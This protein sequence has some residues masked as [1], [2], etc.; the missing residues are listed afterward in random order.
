MSRWRPFYEPFSQTIRDT[1]SIRYDDN[2]AP[3]ELCN[4]L[5]GENKGLANSITE[6]SESIKKNF[7]SVYG[8]VEERNKDIDKMIQDAQQ[9]NVV[10]QLNKV[11]GTMDAN[12]QAAFKALKDGE[13]KY[14]QILQTIE[15]RNDR[16]VGSFKEENEKR[17]KNHGALMDDWKKAHAGIVASIAK[18]TDQDINAILQQV[19]THNAKLLEELTLGGQKY[20]EYTNTMTTT[21]QQQN[22]KLADTFRDTNSTVLT[23]LQDMDSKWETQGKVMQESISGMTFD[24]SAETQNITLNLEKVVERVN[25]HNTWVLDELTANEDVYSEYFETVI[26]KIDAQNG[27][28]SDL[29]TEAESENTCRQVVKGANAAEVYEADEDEVVAQEA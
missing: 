12:N 25:T 14:N 27:L 13:A 19:E 29:I 11:A 9:I 15:E 6:E 26:G 21:L 16:L 1:T 7:K 17:K 4:T 24:E 20:G 5:A 28:L 22:A 23:Q 2:E 8:K 3:Y 18:N 10:S